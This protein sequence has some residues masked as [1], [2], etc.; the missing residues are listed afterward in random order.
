M[1]EQLE[2]QLKNIKNLI[3][4]DIEDIL[5]NTYRLLDSEEVEDYNLCLSIICHVANMS[6]SDAMIQQLLH[7]CIVKSRIFL[8]DHLLSQKDQFYKPVISA[9]DF[10][11]RSLYTS[12]TT[13]TVLTKPQKD[14]FDA[15]Q[16]N[17]RLVVS[18]PTSFGK[19]RIIRE[20]ISHNKYKNIVLIMPTVSLL[21]EQYQDL[22]ANVKGYTL[23]K[24]SKVKIDTDKNYILVLTLTFPQRFGP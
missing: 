4:L 11:L 13:D 22:R 5:I 19:T 17:R 23:S 7:D 9:H 15:F 8:Y 14:I 10:L 1:K 16:A 18:A 3:N 2:N 6:S 20:I 12:S 24:S 21:S